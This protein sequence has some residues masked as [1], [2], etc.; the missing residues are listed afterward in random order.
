MSPVANLDV[1]F[2]PLKLG[3]FEL[4]NRFVY[5]PLTRCRALESIPQQSAAEYYSQRSTAGG[6][7]IAEGTIVEP[8]GYGCGLME[9]Y[10]VF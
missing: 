1:L 2:Q 9:N 3:P 8:R 10:L 7:V 4:S 5:P 6:L